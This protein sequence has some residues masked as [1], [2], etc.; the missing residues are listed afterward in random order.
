MK[1]LFSPVNPSDLGMIRGSYPVQPSTPAVAGSEG[2]AQVVS[3]GA[4]VKGLKEGDIVVPAVMGLG[5]SI[6]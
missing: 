3:V 2:V 6:F 4:G 1:F 5:M